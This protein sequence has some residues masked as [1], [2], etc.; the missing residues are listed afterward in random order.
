MGTERPCLQAVINLKA[1][2]LE[3]KN[4][5]HQ[6]GL[7]II[8][9]IQGAGSNCSWEALQAQ[10]SW[11]AGQDTPGPGLKRAPGDLGDQRAGQKGRLPQEGTSTQQPLLV[12]AQTFLRHCL[13]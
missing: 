13:I 10:G 1:R 12:L 2:A 7:L 9:D 6:A 5:S 8:G 3:D 11:G 4:C